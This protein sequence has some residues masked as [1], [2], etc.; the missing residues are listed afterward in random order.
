[1]RKVVPVLPW[2]E[3][4][5]M[6]KVLPSLP[7]SLGECGHNGAR[8]I[9]VNV[10]NVGQNEARLNLRLWEKQGGNEARAI[11]PDV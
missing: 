6:R 11:L 3:E 4:R 8:L 7:G 2:K 1:M 5:M 9:S 10:V